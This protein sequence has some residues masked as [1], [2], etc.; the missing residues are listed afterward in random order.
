[1][2]VRILQPTRYNGTRYKLGDTP[3]VDRVAAKGLIDAGSAEPFDPK[4]AA[5]ADAEAKAAAKASA[6]TGEKPAET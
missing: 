4:A 5:R 2:K 3:E 1:M 6:E